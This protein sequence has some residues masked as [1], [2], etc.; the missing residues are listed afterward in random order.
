[1]ALRNVT[2]GVYSFASKPADPAATEDWQMTNWEQMPQDAGQIVSISYRCDW[3]AGVLW[4]RTYDGSDRSTLIA[5][6]VIT[7]AE[8]EYDPANNVLPPH[9]EW[10]LVSRFVAA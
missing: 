2:G 5:R 6:A 10:E 1:L 7:D 8:Q 9:G 4:C 3:D